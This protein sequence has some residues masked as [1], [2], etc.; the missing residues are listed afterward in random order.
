M[1]SDCVDSKINKIKP[2]FDN[3]LN[4]KKKESVAQPPVPSI[5]RP[6]QLPTSYLP[7]SQAPNPSNS[8]SVIGSMQNLPPKPVQLQIKQ[9]LMQGKIFD[10]ELTIKN[11]QKERA[12]NIFYLEEQNAR[13]RLQVKAIENNLELKINPDKMT[14]ELSFKRGTRY[15]F[16]KPESGEPKWMTL[17]NDLKDEKLVLYCNKDGKT[18]K[19]CF[20]GI[21]PEECMKVEAEIKTEEKERPEGMEREE[22]QDTIDD[23]INFAMPTLQQFSDTEKFRRALSTIVL[24]KRI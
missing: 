16:A 23:I 3:Y 6:D 1:F 17:T 8:S 20:Q 4:D 21:V 18:I 5:R 13:M 15:K 22:G 10:K 9:L 12:I 7:N 14:V 19:S 24:T 11:I 2:N